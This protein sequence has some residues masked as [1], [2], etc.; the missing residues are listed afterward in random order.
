VE[1]VIHQSLCGE[2]N[3]KAWDLLQTT[4][5]DIP[6]AKKIA[7]NTD[8]QDQA[9][10][11]LWKP[12]IRGFIQDDY[13]LLMKTFPDKSPEVRPGRTFSH[14][15]IIPKKYIGLIADI[16]CLFKYLPNEINKTISLE[17]I[18]FDTYTVSGITVPNG[19]QERFNKAIHGF[20]NLNDFKSTIIWVGEENFELA[21]FKFWQVLSSE[22]KEKL[23]FG[24][25][26]NVVAIPGDKLNF[27]TTPENTESKFLNAGF[28]LI[29][30]NDKQILTEISEQYLA[31]ETSAVSR[32][33]AF[34]QAIESNEFSRTDINKI[35]I[36]IKNF[37]EIDSVEDLK[38]LITLSHIVAEFSTDKKSGLGFKE[39]LVAKISLLIEHGDVSYIPLVKKF[40]LKSFSK[41]KI[42]LE[43]AI[44]KWLDNNLFSLS[45]TKKNDFATLFRK[46]RESTISNW[47]N[48]L[49]NTRIEKF[50]DKI[51]SESV[52]IIFNWLQ[53]D[54][55]IF[56]NI[57][58]S[59]DSTIESENHFISGLPVRFDKSNFAKLKEFALKRNWYKLYATILVREH[60]FELAAAEQ[61][62]VDND[63]NSVD[64][65]EIIINKV[66]PK[67][68]I[69]FA[70]SNGDK[71]LID[72]SS[73]VCAEDSTQLERIDF[74][75]VNWQHIWLK[76]IN[77]GNK[78]FD[79]FK[80]P[81]K[82]VIEIFDNIIEGN[83]IDEQLLELISDTECGNILDYENREM[84]WSKFS[85]TLQTKFLSKTSSSLLESLSINPTA[86]VPNDK[87]L[88]DYIIKFAIF[89]FLFYNP[90]KNVLP[91]L[92]RFNKIPEDYLTTY[93]MRYEGQISVIEATQLGKIVK[94][95]NFKNVTYSIYSKSSKNN[96]WK[97]ALAESHHL[98]DFFTKSKLRFLGILDSVNITTNQW[99]ESAEEHICDLYPNGLSITSIWKKAGGKESELLTNTT[100]RNMWGDVF[101]KLRN[102]Q[103]KKVTM[104]SL[105]K[106]VNKTYGENEKFK[107][108]YQ[109][110]KN[111]ISC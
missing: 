48:T 107:L 98:L 12:T 62:K 28:C 20:K 52:N 104:N 77:N 105:L 1:I 32:I 29:R 91:I 93:I 27:I 46:L 11:I 80:E 64:G 79:G 36:V 42:K 53:S 83:S 67:A 92:H 100:T 2:N 5:L 86:K 30:R 13:F 24:I 99:W 72:I 16:G 19:F 63:Y 25:N 45:S 15:L 34:K 81:K 75:N 58:T 18:I 40:N 22:E 60:P 97:F 39:K 109:L 71:R 41:S 23:N 90:I 33:N 69:D 9:G 110:R 103:F 102:N 111:Y 74:K 101:S 3:K 31:G 10:G 47:W 65:I 50:L 108:I 78:I 44:N 56:E 38:K 89:D 55:E 21:I 66:K 14:V 95:R 35:A 51:N 26:F 57:Q 68:I 17:P 37:E 6:I 85:T 54:F 76:S 82:K 59:I 49:I 84:L 70:V 106:E 88:S 7:F 73:K 4:M 61:L 94:D 43:V 8:L 96:N 87:I